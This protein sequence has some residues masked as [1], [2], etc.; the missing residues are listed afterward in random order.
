[1]SELEKQ[2]ETK[3]LFEK[4]MLVFATVEPLATIPQ[5]YKIWSTGD[6][7]GVSLV[8]WIF[9]AITS[10]IWLVYGIKS[11]DKPIILSGLL[12]S[13]TQVLVVIGIVTH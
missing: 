9:Y 2:R 3:N 10:A 6:T 12:W 7:S 11:K 4:F 5:I 13:A 8:T 1:M